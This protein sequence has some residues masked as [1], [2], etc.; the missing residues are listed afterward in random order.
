MINIEVLNK[1]IALT[2]N[3]NIR[4]AEALYLKLLEEEPENY[5][6]LSSLGLFYVN[7][8]NFEKASEKLQE[9]FRL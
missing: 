5:L 3:G 7:I 9:R 4:E 2:Q 8:Q 6:I 1:A